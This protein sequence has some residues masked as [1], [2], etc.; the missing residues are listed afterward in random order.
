MTA[1][2]QTRDRA[3][4][5]LPFSDQLDT[6]HVLYDVIYLEGRRRAGMHLDAAERA[7]L[8]ALLEVFGGDPGWSRRRHRRMTLMVPAVVKSGSRL[9]RAAL[10]NMSGGGAYL[11]SAIPAEVGSEVLVKVG[12][13]DGGVQYSFPCRV[14]RSRHERGAHHLALAFCGIPLQLRYGT[15][16][17][18]PLRRTRP[19]RRCADGVG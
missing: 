3:H 6:V 1:R 9:G 18:E 8:Y 11:A 4:A 16:R 12:H 13:P 19:L 15:R 2:S 14:I 10:L 17:P 7:Q 5:T